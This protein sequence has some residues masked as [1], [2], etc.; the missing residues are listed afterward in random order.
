MFMILYPGIGVYPGRALQ[1]V[2]LPSYPSGKTE[3]SFD[4]YNQAGTKGTIS[5]VWDKNVPLGYKWSQSNNLL[6]DT[7]PNTV[8]T[9]NFKLQLYNADL[10]GSQNVKLKLSVINGKTNTTTYTNDYPVTI[11]DTKDPYYFNVSLDTAAWLKN[12]GDTTVIDYYIKT[13]L[14]DSHGIYQDGWLV[15]FKIK[16]GSASNAFYI[17][18]SYGGGII[19][20]IDGTG[21]HGLIAA[22]DHP[23]IFAAWGCIL[24][25]IGGTST[26]IGTGQANT[27]AIIGG[28][29]EASTAARICD[30]LV[31]N[32]FSDWF[33]PSR[34]ELV[35]A[36]LLGE[37]GGAYDYWS[38]SEYDGGNAMGCSSGGSTINLR[39]DDGAYVC[40]VRA[41]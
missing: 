12:S 37:F 2:S 36:A 29:G 25:L 3:L 19:F 35:Q 27:S 34:D 14:I 4:Y 1:T 23:P 11:S 6:F 28:C 17:G 30:D 7:L 38:S 33:L 9:M 10:S 15:K 26:A 5:L 32:G 8:K 20:Y 22:I 18:Q 24:T 21:K 41:F 16:G 40:P 39:K 31:R 13:Q